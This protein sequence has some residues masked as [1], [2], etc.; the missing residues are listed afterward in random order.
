MVSQGQLFSKEFSKWATF[1]SVKS[2]VG[3][4]NQAKF[5]A[6]DIIQREL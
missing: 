5:A 2:G 6:P 4:G 1:L 3:L